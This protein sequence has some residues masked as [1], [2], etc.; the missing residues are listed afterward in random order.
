MSKP[1]E[2][3]NLCYGA[4]FKVLRAFKKKTINQWQLHNRL[5]NIED[6]PFN[7]TPTY[8]TGKVAQRLRH[9]VSQGEEI[10]NPSTV[11]SDYAN[12]KKPETLPMQ[13]ATSDRRFAQNFLSAEF[14]QKILKYVKTEILMHLTDLGGLAKALIEMLSLTSEDSLAMTSRLYIATDPAISYTKYEI[15]STQTHFNVSSLVAGIFHY[16]LYSFQS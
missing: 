13:R 7:V 3:I 8:P 12:C 10:L 11:A 16:S 5:M 15:I 2:Q 14:H 1:P 9:G 4:F 6:V